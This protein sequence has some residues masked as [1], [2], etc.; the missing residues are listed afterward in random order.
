[1]KLIRPA[2]LIHS[3]ALEFPGG[4]VLLAKTVRVTGN[5]WL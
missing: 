3:R 4:F 2:A 5:I 1:M